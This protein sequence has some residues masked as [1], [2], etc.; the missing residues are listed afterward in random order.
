MKFPLSPIFVLG[1]DTGVGK[2]VLSLLLM[3]FFYAEGCTP[4]YLKPLQTGC[5]DPYDTD[6]DAQFIY[7]H[8]EPLQEKDPADSVIFCYNHPKAPWFAAR[9]EG[10]VVEPDRIERIVRDKQSR[11]TPLIIEGAGGLFVPMT[12]RFMTPDL[13]QLSGARPLVAA[14]AGLG[15]INH[16][17]LT[18]EVLEHR[19]LV[20]LGVVFLDAG[21]IPTPTEMI[22]ENI[23]AVEHFSG[24]NV[25]GVI[26]RIND[27]SRPP[28]AV[29]RIFRN[30]FKNQ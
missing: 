25:A 10:K 4:F 18:L 14:R 13:M 22:D 26:P 24:I 28:E 1:T 17:L 5:R 8:V 7:R 9:D 12:K 15:T 21:K 27:F 19:G 20:P 23:E 16:T 3:R 11:Y 29:H 30:L 2:T 6:S